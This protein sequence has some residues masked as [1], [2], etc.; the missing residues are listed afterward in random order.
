[1]DTIRVNA[2]TSYNVLVGPG[3]LSEAGTLITEAV[4]KARAA[5][6]VS[7]DNVYPLYGGPLK[8]ALAG[9]DLNCMNSSSRT[10]SRTKRSRPGDGCS[11][12]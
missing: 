6:I 4:P 9:S 7:D 11:N 5:M 3:L 8:A 10:G 12:A 1:M 2:S